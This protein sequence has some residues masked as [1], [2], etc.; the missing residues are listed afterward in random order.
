MAIGPCHP[1]E[2][3]TD[4]YTDLHNRHPCQPLGFDLVSSYRDGYRVGLWTRTHRMTINSDEKEIMNA[5]KAI[6]LWLV[7]E[8]D[9][10]LE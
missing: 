4:R 5:I 10:D 7:L 3:S 6:L 9:I 1:F 2:S 8:V